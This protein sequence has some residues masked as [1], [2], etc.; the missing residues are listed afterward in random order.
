MVMHLEPQLGL[1]KFYS[2]DSSLGLVVMHTF[3]SHPFCLNAIIGLRQVV[4][5]KCR[6]CSG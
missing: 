4:M 6:L 5:H 3:G 1:W 2:L